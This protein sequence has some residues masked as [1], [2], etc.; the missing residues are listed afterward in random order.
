LAVYRS[1]KHIYAQLIDDDAATTVC[2]VSTLSA[3]LKGAVEGANGLGRAKA[4]GEAL[5]ELAK[6]KN[7]T[8]VIFDRGGFTYAGQ[9]KALAD[10]ARA[11]GLEF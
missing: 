1:N 10:A 6:E 7:V 3:S 2:A 8:T 9:I 4:V 5:G 11:K